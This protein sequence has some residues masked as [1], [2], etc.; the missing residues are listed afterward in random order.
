MAEPSTNELVLEMESE[1][2]DVKN[3]L[4]ELEKA[5]IEVPARLAIDL[6]ETAHLLTGSVG[7]RLSSKLKG[8]GSI[9]EAERLISDVSS[10]ID[11]DKLTELKRIRENKN[12]TRIGISLAIGATASGL[13]NAIFRF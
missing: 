7:Y 5:N 8:N 11:V 10:E 6:A 12:W 2:V 9:L 4:G 13:L 3:K 1:L